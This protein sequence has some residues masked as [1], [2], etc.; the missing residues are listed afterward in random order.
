M[1]KPHSLILVFMFALSACTASTQNIGTL[2]LPTSNKKIDV[3]Q[4]RSSTKDGC[5]E[6]VVIQTYQFD[7]VLLDSQSGRATALPCALIGAAIE[8]GAYAGSAAIIANGAAK[9]AS[10]ISNNVSV[11]SSSS[12]GNSGGPSGREHGNNG[13]GNGG[14]DGSNGHHGD[15]DR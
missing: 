4:H 13:Y 1:K 7:G 15:S 2:V 8:A 10:K 6:L 14:H 9:A 12:G 3:V 11:T 5:A